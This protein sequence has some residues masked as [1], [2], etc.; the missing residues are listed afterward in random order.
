MSDNHDTT[1]TTANN[2]QHSP[3]NTHTSD[4]IRRRDQNQEVS[5]R[6]YATTTS[7]ALKPVTVDDFEA[8][9][10]KQLRM[11]TSC[12]DR[13][14]IQHRNDILSYLISFAW[15]QEVVQDKLLYIEQFKDKYI[16]ISEVRDAIDLIGADEISGCPT[17]CTVLMEDGRGG[18][19][20]TVD[21]KPIIVTFGV[22]VPLE[23]LKSLGAALFIF[24]RIRKYYTQP[25]QMPSAI[26]VIDLICRPED[27]LLHKGSWDSTLFEFCK[28]MPTNSTCYICGA[29]RYFTAFF[30]RV[31]GL[32]TFTSDMTKNFVLCSSYDCLKGVIPVENML[33]S[34]DPRGAFDFDCNAYRR[35]L[36]A[37]SS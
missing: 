23:P 8:L 29:N 1:A 17:P 5:L 20:T 26:L 18:C 3:A 34:W 4:E 16:T 36:L 35:Y 21:G 33:P 6:D 25:S 13:F 24:N 31:M 32:S 10:P 11:L 9:T 27:S 37:T 15:D 7:A 30:N 28:N 12:C 2:F 22:P 19:A 14:G